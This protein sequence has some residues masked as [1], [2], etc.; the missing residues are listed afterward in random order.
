MGTSVAVESWNAEGFLR[1]TIIFIV[2]FCVW[3]KILLSGS[4][5]FGIRALAS[6][7]Q[8]V[9]MLPECSR[10][11]FHLMCFNSPTWG[12]Q[13]CVWKCLHLWFIFCSVIM[14][15]ETV[16][17]LDPVICGNLY[18]CPCKLLKFTANNAILPLNLSWENFLLDSNF[19]IYTG[20]WMGVL[21]VTIFSSKIINDS[22]FCSK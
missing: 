17:L 12:F 20:Y 22:F 16:R 13:K 5:Y 8:R 6:T 15:Y 10:G 14:L 2:H 21:S 1:P 4:T 11:L 3:P 7:T 18:L 9:R 19:K